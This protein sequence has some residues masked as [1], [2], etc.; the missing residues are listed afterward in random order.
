M[1]PEPPDHQFAQPA[2]VTQAE[3][4]TAVFSFPSGSSGGIDGLKPQH[5][6][7]MLGR[8]DDTESELCKSLTKLVNHV[9]GKRFPKKYVLFSSEELLLHCERKT[10]D[11]DR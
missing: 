2:H 4:L 10:E 8:R 3:V 11:F 6:K 5:M 1:F 9:S 7:D